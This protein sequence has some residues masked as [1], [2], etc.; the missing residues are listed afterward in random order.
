MSEERSIYGRSC[1]IDST[2]MTSADF[3]RIINRADEAKKELVDVG[4]RYLSRLHGNRLFANDGSWSFVGFC[5]NDD[6]LVPGRNFVIRFSPAW[7]S[8]DDDVETF[9]VPSCVLDDFEVGVSVAVQARYE[10]ER[11]RAL[12]KK[13][14]EK[15][16]ELAERQLYLRLKA[17]FEKEGDSNE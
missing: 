15:V 16:K 11:E 12:K 1:A 17:K 10:K 9:F 5:D 14:M 3:E 2:N 13:E 6:A 8:D 7:G 4:I